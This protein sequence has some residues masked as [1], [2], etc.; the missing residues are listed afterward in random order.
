MF[1]WSGPSARLST[2]TEN[3]RYSSGICSLGLVLIP[4][5]HHIHTNTQHRVSHSVNSRKNEIV[6]PQLPKRHWPSSSVFNES[7]FTKLDPLPPSWEPVQLSF[8][9]MLL[10]L[11][12]WLDQAVFSQARHVTSPLTSKSLPLTCVPFRPSV[13]GQFLIIFT[14]AVLPTSCSSTLQPD[15]YTGFPWLLPKSYSKRR[16]MLS[17]H[18]M[19]IFRPI[20]IWLLGSLTLLISR[21][22]KL[23]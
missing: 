21:F 12:L 17:S 4:R 22:Q 5:T 20:F 1:S 3:P 8:F 16:L 13:S 23:S 2:I 9:S 10:C 14:P 6:N 7:F 15:S 11:V 19:D 18:P